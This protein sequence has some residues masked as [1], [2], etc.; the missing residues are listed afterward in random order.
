MNS[1][2]D[3]IRAA[4]TDRSAI[5]ASAEARLAVA[6]HEA[7]YHRQRLAQ[8]ERQMSRLCK[9]LPGL[10]WNRDIYADALKRTEAGK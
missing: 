5:L 9:A 1:E 10:R 3:T 7:G 4:L 8:L 6:K 2:L